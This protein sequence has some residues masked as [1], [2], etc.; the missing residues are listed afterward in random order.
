[1][2]NIVNPYGTIELKNNSFKLTFG[3]LYDDKIS[4]IYKKEYP[5]TSSNK[6]GDIFDVNS[7][8]NDLKKIKVIDDDELRLKIELNEV[9]LILQPYGLD[10]FKSENTTETTSIDSKIQKLDIKN[11]INMAKKLSV[12]EYNEIV[13]IVPSVFFLD[14]NKAFNEPPLGF[15][16]KEIKVNSHVYSLPK[17]Y[18]ENVKNAIINAG[19]GIKKVVIAPL[20]VASLLEKENLDLQKYLLIDYN[21]DNTIVS[22]IANN[23][24]FGSRYFSLGGYDVTKDIANNFEISMEN[25][26]NLKKIYG[27]DTRENEFNPPIIEVKSDDGSIKKFNKNDLN[28]VVSSSLNEW[29]KMFSN[30]VDTLLNDYN[31]LKSNIPLVFIGNSTKINGF[32][33]FIS[34]LYP[35]NKLVFYKYNAFGG[36]SPSDVKALGAISFVSTY[37]G[38]LEDDTRIE[39]TKINRENNV[40]SE[41]DDEL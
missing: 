41:E 33:E 38:S 11:V 24:V 37:K 22:F 40:Y 17:E 6:D 28:E 26:E 31:D 10:V 36:D 3:Y 2:N 23:K 14:N 4:V 9:V 30:C 32:K 13:D 8:T 27:F 39:I 34:Y 5:L 16:S 19:L 18:V 25:A 15:V 12:G 7:L 21:S 1:M 29:K 20:G 35:S